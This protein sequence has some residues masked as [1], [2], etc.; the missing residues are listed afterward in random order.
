MSRLATRH[1][2]WLARSASIAAVATLIVTVDSQ[3]GDLP[4]VN[5]AF[6]SWHGEAAHIVALSGYELQSVACP[7]VTTCYAVGATPPA[8]GGGL[9]NSVVIATVDGGATW[10]IKQRP[11]GR[12]YI[13][14]ACPSVQ[15]CYVVGLVFK[16][17]H[18]PGPVVTSSG[19][20]LRSTD[21]A[22]SW[23]TLSLRSVSLAPSSVSP[24]GIACATITTCMVVGQANVS[25]LILVTFDAGTSWRERQADTGLGQVV[26]CP[27]RR[28]CYVGA[29]ADP[30]T[31]PGGLFVTNNAGKN[32]R[33][34]YR[35]SNG[36][37]F[38]IACPRPAICYALMSGGIA[39][40]RNS[41]RSW[42]RQLTLGP[43]EYGGGIACPTTSVCYSASIDDT[44]TI[45]R[46]T[47][48]SGRRW[49][50]QTVVRT[51]GINDLI[52]PTTRICVAV[53]FNSS[54][55][56]LEGVILRTSDGGTTW[57]KV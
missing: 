13:A 3:G 38:A 30:T 24:V 52:C 48:T 4:K 46:A 32:W 51:I 34:G 8:P 42:H 28:T 50:T 53:G 6:A 7:S 35:L 57:H 37:F 19:I 54:L 26:A 11:Q 18:R 21:G 43:R 36:Q 5:R 2:S 55:S 1:N 40:S 33:R 56:G 25:G 9:A 45:L 22:A 20:V 41:G 27:T 39:S 29:P 10:T 15:R 44:T 12:K 23:Q 16:P 47:A 17:S 49:S 14:I 31:S